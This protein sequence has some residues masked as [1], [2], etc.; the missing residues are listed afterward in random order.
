MAEA[1]VRFIFA[2]P[3]NMSLYENVPI[4]PPNGTSLPIRLRFQN[5]RRNGVGEFKHCFANEAK[6]RTGCEENKHT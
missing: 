3:L 1:I 5:N 6:F 2:A 4:E